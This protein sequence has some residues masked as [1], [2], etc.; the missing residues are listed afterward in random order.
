MGFDDKQTS[1]V[2]SMISKLLNCHVN[3]IIHS[4]G[5]YL[6]DLVCIDFG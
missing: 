3:I 4:V 2:L 1:S 6:A 5:Y